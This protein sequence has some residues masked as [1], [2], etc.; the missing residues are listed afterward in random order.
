VIIWT[1]LD[2]KRSVTHC[3]A[4]VDEPGHAAEL[5]ATMPGATWEV[6]QEMPAPSLAEVQAVAVTS[7]KA[8]ASSRILAR[9]P[10]ATQANMTAAAVEMVADNKKSGPEWVAIRAAWDWV[11]AVRA[12]SNRVEAA[13]MAAVDVAG[14]DAAAAGATWPE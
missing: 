1:H 12:E 9:Y 13:I 10:A 8:E 11:K 7:V 14:V 6:S 5:S 2:G 3:A 4:G